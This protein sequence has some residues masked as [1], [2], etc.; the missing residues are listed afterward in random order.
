MVV[1]PGDMDGNGEIT[2]SD[3]SDLIDLILSGNATASAYPAADVNG[4]GQ[5]NIV[6]VSELID[7]LLNKQV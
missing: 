2:I 1:L 3:V 4:D 7:A 6:D 5:I